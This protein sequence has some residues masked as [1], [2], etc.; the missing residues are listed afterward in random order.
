M[1]EIYAI[2][3][4]KILNSI[5]KSGTIQIY[6]WHKRIGIYLEI[7]FATESLLTTFNSRNDGNYQVIW[8]G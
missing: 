1:T 5:V 4:D 3:I 7:T 2:R 8:I 6:S